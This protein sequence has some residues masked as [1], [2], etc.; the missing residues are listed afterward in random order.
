MNINIKNLNLSV[1]IPTI[2]GERPVC[3]ESTPVRKDKTEK[4]FNL[5]LIYKDGHAEPFTGENGKENVQYIGL[6]Y[7][8]VT[9]AISL[10]EHEDVQL[11]DDDS[12]EKDIDGICYGRECDAL[13]DFDGQK[14]TERLVAR[15]PKLKSLLKAGE[16]IPSLGQLNLMA[17]YRDGINDA[18]KYIGAKLLSSTW[19]WSSTEYSRTYAWYVYFS[20]GNTL[21]NLKCNSYRVRAVAA[22]TFKL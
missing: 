7:E 8:N 15:N 3:D 16:Y 6:R 11:L 18:L 9:F 19:F 1:I 17:H 20:N 13:F 5:Y 12:P 10:A 2:K 14:N 22:F 4:P 21:I